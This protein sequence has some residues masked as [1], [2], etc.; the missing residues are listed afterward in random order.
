MRITTKNNKRENNKLPLL[1]GLGG[2][3]KY[4]TILNFY[5]LSYKYIE[6]VKMTWQKE[7]IL[8]NTR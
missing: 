2:Q 4:Q 6:K 1:N 5:I 8:I 7:M 3:V